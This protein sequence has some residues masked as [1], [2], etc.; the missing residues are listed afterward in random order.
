MGGR[1]FLLDGA[2]NLDGVQAL[3]A[4]LQGE[5]GGGPFALVLGMLGDKDCELMCR[6]LAPLAGRIAA[7]RVGSNRSLQPAALAEFCR[8]ANPAALVTAH[9]SVGDALGALLE[10]RRGVIAGSLYLIGEALE[11]LG[12][13]ATA[14]ERGLNEWQPAV[15][16]G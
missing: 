6:A 2:H 7:V 15:R 16:Q 14:G 10:E 12:L 1:E 5:F 8:R 11:R 4:A 9:E 3:V 13:D